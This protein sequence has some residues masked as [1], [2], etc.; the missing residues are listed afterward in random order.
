MGDAVGSVANL[1]QGLDAEGACLLGDMLHEVGGQGVEHFL[2]GF[3]GEQ[4]RL[5]GGEFP[6]GFG[7]QRGEEWELILNVRSFEDA[8]GDAV[9]DVG[10]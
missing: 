10:S 7:V 6:L 2:E 4:V 1:L 5:G 3:V 8:G 9:F